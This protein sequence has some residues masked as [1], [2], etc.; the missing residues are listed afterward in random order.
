MLDDLDEGA[1]PLYSSPSISSDISMNEEK[2]G[3]GDE[4]DISGDHTTQ[5]EDAPDDEEGIVRIGVGSGPGHR[6]GRTLAVEYVEDSDGE[7]ASWGSSMGR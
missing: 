4:G 3:S 1:S 7:G 6:R 2:Q 5:G